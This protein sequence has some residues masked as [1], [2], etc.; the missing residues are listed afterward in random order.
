VISRLVKNK[1]ILQQSM[2]FKN[3]RN[4]LFQK[5]NDK[6]MVII[7]SWPIQYLCHDVEYTYKQDPNFYYYTGFKESDAI[8]VFEKS[9]GVEKFTLFVKEKDEKMET[10][11]GFIHGPDLTVIKFDADQAFNNEHFKEY[12]MEHVMNYKYLYNWCPDE[13]SQEFKFVQ[14]VHENLGIEIINCVEIMELQRN[15]K[16]EYEIN[17]IKQAC[18]ISGKAHIL[19][20]KS[21]KPRMSE[22]H[23]DALINGFAMYNGCKRLAYTNIVA[24]GNNATTLHYEN[25]DK[26]LNDGDILLIDAGGEYE[27]YASDISRSFP[28]NGK[29]TNEQRQIYQIVL[30][31]QKKCIE[32]V[33]P[34]VTIMEIHAYSQ[35]LIAEGLINIGLLNGLVEDVVNNED[36]KKFY[37]HTIGHFMGLDVHDCDFIDRG[38][39]K[40]VPG[41]VFTIEPGIYISNKMVVPEE[42]KGI[43]IRIEDD[44]LVT[45]DGCEVLSCHCPKEI[46]EIEKIVGTGNSNI[47]DM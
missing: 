7:G 42:Y 13:K 28:V 45:N 12:I 11:T 22:K 18:E 4:A 19:A 35:R 47:F 16:T 6:S 21:T 8:A 34:G 32:M 5:I 37:M 14:Y 10:W 29:F 43:G 44:I 46:N 39:Y 23:I 38:G 9:N 20:M 36:I 3:R 30:D 25:N 15:V 1:I 17:L 33:K 41:N 24:G 2:E 40:L 26:E 31:C 27:G